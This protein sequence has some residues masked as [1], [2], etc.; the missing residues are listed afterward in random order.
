MKSTG[1]FSIG[2]WKLSIAIVNN[3]FSETYMNT[4]LS[5]ASLPT[6]IG[7]FLVVVSTK[8]LCAL[9]LI[10]GRGESAVL[11][12]IRRDHPGADLVA[13]E[14]A[15]RP[16]ARKIEAVIAGRLAAADVPLDMRGTPFQKRVWRELVRVPWGKTCSYSELA[17]KVGAPRAVRAV[18]SACARNPVTFVVPCHRILRKGGGLGGYYWGL[19]MKRQLL[20]REAG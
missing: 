5:Y 2:N 10:E 3:A 4:H 19:E 7:T 16:L 9:R 12:E 20:E 1:R 18:A 15:V 17:Q 13:D 6:P 8:G 11:A 14:K